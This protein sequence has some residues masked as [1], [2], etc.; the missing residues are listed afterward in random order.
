MSDIL[1]PVCADLAGA[2]FDKQKTAEQV[3]EILLKI[4]AFQE[5]DHEFASAQRAS[6][7]TNGEELYNHPREYEVMLGLY[8]TFPCIKEADVLLYVPNGW[9][10]LITDLGA[11]L[12]IDV[13]HT[14]RKPDATSRYEFR[15][16]SPTDEALA[17]AA[18]RPRI[19]EDVVST[20][21]SVAGVRSLLLPDQDVHVLAMLGRD[22][23]GINEDYA[24]GMTVHYLLQRYISPNAEEFWHS[25]EPQAT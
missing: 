19:G 1:K 11:G 22:P 24:A 21:G 8:A 13:A 14:E 2:V 6:L 12:G 20:L 7:K 10:K 9:R 25:L 16:S 3:W 23:G 17:R 5:G 15:F 4:G 18:L